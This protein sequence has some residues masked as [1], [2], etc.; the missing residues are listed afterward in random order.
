MFEPICAVGAFIIM[1]AVTE[2]PTLR[3]ETCKLNTTG[4]LQ[5]G[6]IGLFY[7]LWIKPSV[8]EKQPI[9]G[10]LAFK[11]RGSRTA[12][13]SIYFEWSA[14]QSCAIFMWFAKHRTVCICF[15]VTAA[16]KRLRCNFHWVHVLR[17]R[18]EASQPAG[19]AVSR[20]PC[21][22]LKCVIP[23]LFS[24]SLRHSNYSWE[25]IWTSSQLTVLD[26]VSLWKVLKSLLSTFWPSFFIKFTHAGDFWDNMLLSL[27][28]TLTG[29]L[30]RLDLALS[31][32][33]G[34]YKAVK[35]KKIHSFSRLPVAKNNRSV[36]KDWTSRLSSTVLCKMSS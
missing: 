11:G 26:D 31:V 13:F 24:Q 19:E 36:L 32:R 33:L 21:C 1:M 12:Y 2:T 28:S 8:C 3:L 4:W 29:T 20:C 14:M 23:D 34:E 22:F 25:N 7:W 5:S 15:L 16:K 9:R 18:E 10:K 17:N 27:K 6:Y 35:K 30:N